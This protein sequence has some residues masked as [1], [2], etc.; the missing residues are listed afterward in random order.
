MSNSDQSSL[1]QGSAP[2]RSVLRRAQALLDDVDRAVIPIPIPGM[3]EIARVRERARGALSALLS[4]R[5]GS[6]G[7]PRIVALAGS[8]G[9][10]KSALF[11]ELASGEFSPTSVQR[12]GTLTPVALVHPADEDAFAG[13]PLAAHVKV[14]ISENAQQ[15]IVLVDCPPWDWAYKKRYSLAQLVLDYAFSVVF[16]STIYRYGDGAAWDMLHRLA[17]QGVRCAA[18]LNRV[19]RQSN[20]V[21]ARDFQ[22][23]WREA[24]FSALRVTV[25]H[26][27]ELGDSRVPDDADEVLGAAED[28]PRDASSAEYLHELSTHA[29]E[30]PT[31][32]AHV[33]S[34]HRAR[35]ALKRHRRRVEAP[36][37]HAHRELTARPVRMGVD[38]VRRWCAV[39]AHS[40]S[41]YRRSEAMV[42]ERQLVRDI[43][44]LAD[45]LDSVRNTLVDLADRA[46]V[47]AM[48]PLDKLATNISMGRFG[49]GAVN[50]VWQG[51]TADHGLLAGVRASAH[52]GSSSRE[53]ADRAAR[54]A[55]LHALADMLAA[56]LV[57]AVR[58]GLH[59]AV[60]NIERSWAAD[61][62]DTEEL[63][64][65]AR[66]HID[67]ADMAVHTVEK[68]KEDVRRIA[69]GAKPQE[70]FG[71]DGVAGLLAVAASGVSGAMAIARDFG[72]EQ[73]AWDARE[74]LAQ[75]IREMMNMLVDTYKNEVKS[76][77]L[78][79]SVRLR[80]DL[81]DLMCAIERVH[82]RAEYRSTAHKGSQ[83]I[84]AQ[85]DGQ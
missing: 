40:H 67:G 37:R 77:E 35:H 47:G 6:G 3:Q 2:R 11:N 20:G 42:N 13:H 73:T 23:L 70:W 48:A 22:R 41:T 79:D 85:G 49:Q 50:S 4:Q 53:C 57:M 80:E 9:V 25:V 76:V 34:A 52:A 66:A 55:Q 68:W 56:A 69:V 61:P 36:G 12:P 18:V 81:R 16:V 58:Q 62:L 24:G 75:R 82:M 44:T 15:G 21:A 43:N 33:R 17:A 1:R 65:H 32:G 74:A 45:A 63:I 26:E 31:H 59:T 7:V 51:L 29:R 60:G 27:G 83:A 14:V 84:N 54:D 38:E 5:S 10:G 71:P 64:A 28:T 8:S 46:H 78:E 30:L 72:W 39:V 19:P